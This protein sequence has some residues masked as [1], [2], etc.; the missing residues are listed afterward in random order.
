VFPKNFLPKAARYMYENDK[1]KPIE[2][3]PPSLHPMSGE[4][5]K[6]LTNDRER[7]EAGQKL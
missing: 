1:N 6:K 2:F 5:W 7:K 3:A 4:I